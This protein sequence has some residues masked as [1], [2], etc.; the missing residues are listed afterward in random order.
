M[1]TIYV[2]HRLF[3]MHDRVLASDVAVRLAG[4]FGAQ[5]IF[6]PYCDSNEDTLESD[7]K[8]FEL[9][10]RDVERLNRLAVMVAILHGPSLD[11]GVCFELGYAWAKGVPI[12]A[13]TTDFQ[14]YS[15]DVNG[16][17][18]VFSDPWIDQAVTEILRVTD[19]DLPVQAPSDYRAFAGRNAAPLDRL[20]DDLVPLVRRLVAGQRPRC[21]RLDASNGLYIEPGPYFA[22]PLWADVSRI[23][24]MSCHVR[25]NRASGLEDEMSL[26][27]A[28]CSI[29]VDARGPET[30][31]GSAFLLG[32]AHARGIPTI[33]YCPGSGFTHAHGREPNARNLMILYGAGRIVTQPLDASELLA[34]V[35][36]PADEPRPVGQP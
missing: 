22:D 14:T 36:R 4:A 10:R 3:G 27:F 26:A 6:L 33:A 29:V 2:A 24:E 20:V 1:D 34:L 28:S 17:Q 32:A 31:P 9:Y 11:D 5:R 35:G 8:G 12:V 30:P 15:N 23:A 16:A 25:Q 13:L 21:D 7:L 19:P 18:S